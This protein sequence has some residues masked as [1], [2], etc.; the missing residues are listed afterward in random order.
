MTAMINGHQFAPLDARLPVAVPSLGPVSLLPRGGTGS[1]DAAPAPG[2]PAAWRRIRWQADG[3]MVIT[4]V[5]TAVVSAVILFAAIVSYSHVHALAAAHRED[6]TQAHLLPLSLDG[7]I[8]EASLVL[9]FAARHKLPAPRL[10]RVMLWAGIAATLGANALVALP[11]QWVGTVANAVIGAVLS[12]WP[13]AAF[14]G[15]VELVMQ[16]VRNVRAVRSVTSGGDTAEGDTGDGGGDND[17]AP[18]NAAPPRRPRP[19][20]R[21]APARKRDKPTVSGAVT[22]K[23]AQAIGDHPEWTAAQVAADAEVS[24]RTVRRHDAWTARHSSR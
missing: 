6:W 5:M 23:V 1:R 17:A 13:A 9:L 20:S 10:A 14:V 2:R 12:A 22:D 7:V 24:V 3:D 18:E 19:A 8:A 15:S 16:L 21:R 4:R 11:P